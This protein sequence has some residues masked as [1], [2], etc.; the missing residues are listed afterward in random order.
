MSDIFVTQSILFLSVFVINFIGTT[1]GGIGLLAYPFV[2]FMGGLPFA[3]GIATYK[4]SHFGSRITSVWALRHQITLSLKQIMGYAI[5]G[6][7]G[8]LIG[9]WIIIYTNN[10]LL[11]Q[12]I[13]YG[14]ILLTI[15]TLFKER[16]QL[17]DFSFPNKK[18]QSIAMYVGLFITSITG[19]ITG[20]G[21]ILSSY[22]FLFINKDNFTAML[23]N[24]KIIS[25][26][27]ALFGS[28]VL[29]S[30]GLVSW[31]LVPTIFI[32]SA[33]GGYCGSKYALKQ[34]ES[35][36]KILSIIAMVSTGL[37]LLF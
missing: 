25:F 4:I 18:T 30:A 1:T 33:L 31:Y 10:E 27:G 29:I 7:A 3:S 9:S 35:F 23:A 22:I 12:I 6:I 21:G 8:A 2:S 11:Q 24:K 19:S 13:G 26:I 36:I 17:L 16:M 15:L 28:S 5:P 34:G 14:I 37:L 32:A 20:G